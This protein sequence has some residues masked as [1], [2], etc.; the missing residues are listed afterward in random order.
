[1]SQYEEE[2]MENQPQTEEIEEAEG[3]EEPNE[4]ETE[5]NDQQLNS[6][7]VESLIHRTKQLQEENSQLKK[8]LEEIST[9]S[10]GNALEYFSKI[11]KEYINK[12]EQLNK[13]IKE[14][15]KNKAQEEKKFRSDKG[16]VVVQL[17]EAQE[18]NENLKLDLDILKNEI[19]KNDK[20]LKKEENVELKNLP[21]NDRLEDLDYQINSLNAEIAK[22][23]Y[24]I[25]DQTEAIN[26]LE[27]T[28]E[29]QSKELN[30]QYEEIKSKYHNLLGSSEI[31]EDQLDKD[32]NEKTKEFKKNMENNIYILTKKLLNS[33]NNLSQ[34]NQE[35]VNFKLNCEKQLLQ[36]NNEISELKN[37]IKDVQTNY[38]L[39]YKLTIDDL[40]KFGN[41]YAKFKTSFFNREKDCINVSNYYKNMMEQY[42]K[43][44]LDEENPNN[45]LEKDYHLKASTVI[46]LQQ[47]NDKLYSDLENLKQ[48]N[49]K[50]SNEIRK[51]I[52]G[53]INNTDKKV[54]ELIKKEKELSTKIKKFSNLYNDLNQRNTNIEK[55]S[56]ENKHI[57]N[58]NKLMENKI[59]NYFNSMGGEEDVSD[60][61]LKI[62]KL[63][64]E[65]SYKDEVL[66]NYEEMFKEDLSEM[67]EQDEVRDD[68]I[69][70]LKNQVEGLKGQ[71]DKLNQT[72][73]NMDNYYT[74]QI[75]DLKNKMKIII[76][77]NNNLRD[78]N[79]IIENGMISQNQKVVDN[80]QKVFKDMKKQF[81]SQS[82][83]ENLI[84]SFNNINNNLLKIKE[85]PEEKELKKLRD[86][87]NEK[88]K[89]IRDL[90]EIKNEGEI[91]Y[92]KNIKEM[93]QTIQEKLNIFN[94]LNNKKNNIL[95]EFEKNLDE[96]NKINENKLNY[97][98]NELE[99][100]EQHKQKL[101][102][103]SQNMKEEKLPQIEGLK[104]Q[105]KDLE[106]QIKEQ[107]EKYFDEIKDIKNNC[108]EQLKIIKDREDYITR[109]TD[110]VSNNLKS[111]ANQNEK[112]V[113]A[114]RQENQQLKNQNYTLS[115]KLS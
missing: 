18:L 48:K 25:K 86:E 14:F 11:R 88:E 21:N 105:I 89:Q 13:Q 66:N 30:D 64:E 74:K 49:Y 62:K 46:N 34:K 57:L 45:K 33:N 20:L 28:Y 12:I 113:E 101:I 92:R 90:K 63:E 84:T 77:E 67:D 115:K 15:E 22:N 43:P 29:T 54:T 103:L 10:K 3:N 93:T 106:T 111:V 40:N 60:M 99:G 27:E 53:N 9:K 4:K 47:E 80:W 81:N 97:S 38:E 59:F 96:F 65:S 71:I 6:T 56:K 2:E 51:E 7:I 8:D 69:K 104:I 83:I 58:E 35:K 50:Q 82:D 19:E 70:R 75:S 112:A 108:D 32:F 100:I 61:K 24:L 109:Q 42:N 102:Q 78:T 114:L 1:M 17:N 68:V 76:D 23:D 98:N 110:I 37:K 73:A 107:N 39:L 91:K 5:E 31:T 36:K 95:N 16:Y 85:F 87:A 79:Q 72:K 26:E 55:L 94:E 41:N 44:L 52:A